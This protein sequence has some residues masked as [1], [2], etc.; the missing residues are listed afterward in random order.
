MNREDDRQPQPQNQN[1]P[2]ADTLRDGNLKASIWRNE[3]ADGSFYATTFSRSYK[4]RDG[5]YHEGQSFVGADLLR[6]S[7][8]ARSAYARTKDLRREDKAQERAD[9]G[10]GNNKERSRPVS[11]GR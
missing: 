3:G 8:L 6:L 10:R 1:R 9:E 11:R 4:D 2:P 7:E 5:A